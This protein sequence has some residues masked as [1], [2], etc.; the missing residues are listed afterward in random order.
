MALGPNEADAIIMEYDQGPDNPS[1]ADICWT[2]VTWKRWVPCL[3]HTDHPDRIRAE[4]FP[5]NTAYREKG[6]D[7]KYIID[8]LKLVQQ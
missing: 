6:K 2:A 7:F 3:V 8:F 1:A 4:L 5:P